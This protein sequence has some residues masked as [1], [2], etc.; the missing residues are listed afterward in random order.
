MQ[1]PIGM[2]VDHFGTRR[3]ILSSIFLCISG[4]VL[5][6]TSDQLS[7]AYLARMMMGTGSACAFLSVSKIINEWFPDSQKGLMMG[8][9]STAGTIGALLGGAPLVMLTTSQGWRTSLMVLAA[10]GIVVLLLNYFV[11]PRSH[12]GESEVTP[13][14]EFSSY[15]ALFMIFKNT[16]AWVFASVAVGLYLSIAVVADLWGV[17]FVIEKFAIEKAEASQM[18]SCIYIGA[19]IGCPLFAWIS[20][21]LNSLRMTILLG[22][23]AVVGLLAYIVF[24]PNIPLW[25]ANVAFFGIG[26]GTGAD[27]LCFTGACTLMG[28]S[29]A[30]TVTGFLNCIV[31]LASAMIQQNVGMVLDYF[32]DGAM[33][34]DHTPI[35][36]IHTYHV[37]FGVITSCTLIFS[38]L[39]FFVKEPLS[40][41]EEI[42]TLPLQKKKIRTALKR[43]ASG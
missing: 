1:I 7:M 40:I 16:Q 6:S 27:I 15:R 25:A 35:Y 36:S 37:A 42:V 26:L 17:S 23:F 3:M 33:T 24:I 10:I 41:D 12:K 2:L 30:A 39:A 38:L 19:A 13:G 43:V 20:R 5:F 18:I 8:L 4:V 34:I 28:P 11:L 9:T 22:G 32:W 29:A 21:T 31:T 14:E